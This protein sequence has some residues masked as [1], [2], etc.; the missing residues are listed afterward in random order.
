MLGLLA[1][2]RLGA[3]TDRILTELGDLSA[4]IKSLRERR[5]I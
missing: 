2:I 4:E 5:V 3:D 1:G